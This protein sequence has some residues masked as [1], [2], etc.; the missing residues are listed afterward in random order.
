MGA[1]IR[2]EDRKAIID[3]VDHLT[4]TRVRA[5][6]LRAGAALVCAGLAAKGSTEIDHLHHIDRGYDDLVGKLK[7]LGADIVRVDE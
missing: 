5:T 2:I 4:G 6:D 1:H 3:G 7:G